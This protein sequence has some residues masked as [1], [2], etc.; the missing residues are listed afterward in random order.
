MVGVRRQAISFIFVVVGA[1][2]VS[3]A[4]QTPFPLIKSSENIPFVSVTASVRRHS[5]Q[6]AVSVDYVTLQFTSDTDNIIMSLMSPWVALAQALF[7]LFFFL[8]SF[9]LE[10]TLCRSLPTSV[11][12]LAKNDQIPS[13][14]TNLHT[15]QC[16]TSVP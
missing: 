5:K 8:H 10:P 3:P 15:A 4:D 11:M 12:E 7:S 14:S 13:G 2:P 9:P 16:L 6:P 1:R